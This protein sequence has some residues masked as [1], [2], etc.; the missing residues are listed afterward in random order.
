MSQSFISEGVLS[1]HI[2]DQLDLDSIELKSG[3]IVNISCRPTSVVLK[4]L[5]F[6]MVNGGELTIPLL[7]VTGMM[8]RGIAEEKDGKYFIVEEDKK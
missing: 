2:E 4:D 8:I 1:I 5:K 6:K 3:N 7:K